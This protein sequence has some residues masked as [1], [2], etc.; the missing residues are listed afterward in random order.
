M[1]DI[2]NLKIEKRNTK[3]NNL[4]LYENINNKYLDLLLNTD[5]LISNEWNNKN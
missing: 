3:L 4:I 1:I 2:L 5:L